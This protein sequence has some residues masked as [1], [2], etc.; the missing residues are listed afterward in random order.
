[1]CGLRGNNAVIDHHHG[2]STS[3]HGCPSH[4]RVD[5]VARND[6]RFTSAEALRVK[7]SHGLYLLTKKEETEGLT[8]RLSMRTANLLGR[9][10]ESRKQIFRDVKSFYHLRSKLV[11]GVQLDPK[12]LNQ[13]RELSSLRETLRKV[14]LSALA[15]FAQEEGALDLPTISDELAFDDQK[16]TAVQARA[17]QFLAG[18]NYPHVN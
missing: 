3:G 6:E 8:Y 7:Q 14:L 13:L 9:D 2:R 4:V 10:A 11:H 16:R 15:L 17:S 5:H 18:N 12:M 1:M